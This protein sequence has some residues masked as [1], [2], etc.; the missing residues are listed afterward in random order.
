MNSAPEIRKS[1]S[2]HRDALLTVLQGQGCDE[3]QLDDDHV[4]KR[5]CI[6]SSKRISRKV[7]LEFIEFYWNEFMCRLGEKP[8]EIIL[9]QHLKCELLNRIDT[10]SYKGEI[11][12]TEPKPAPR[13]THDEAEVIKKVD[14]GDLSI[15]QQQSIQEL[16]DSYIDLAEQQSELPR[17]RKALPNSSVPKSKQVR[18][19]ISKSQCYELLESISRLFISECDTG[20]DFNC[21]RAR[22]IA[23]IDSTFFA[24]L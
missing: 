4:L 19:Y 5:V 17:K 20:V 15:P 9:S 21:V 10:K 14:V 13:R 24:G 16:A 23:L 8:E 11:V 18:K 1:L 7:V 6:T 2:E 22:L 3:M 12:K